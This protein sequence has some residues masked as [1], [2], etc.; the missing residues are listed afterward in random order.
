MSWLALFIRIHML[1]VYGHYIFLTLSVRK[2]ALDVR[3]DRPLAR[4]VTL[5]AP[6]DMSRIER[7]KIFLMAVDP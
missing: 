6:G 5:S 1:W 2:P 3:K 4:R 7:I